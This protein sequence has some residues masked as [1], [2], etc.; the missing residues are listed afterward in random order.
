MKGP[1]HTFLILIISLL[2]G[3]M[4]LSCVEKAAPGNQKRPAIKEDTTKTV[5][6]L[7]EHLIQLEN[8]LI[9]T[10]RLDSLTD[11]KKADSLWASYSKHQQRTLLAINRIDAVRVGPGSKIVVPDTLVEDFN[12]YAPF[13]SRLDILEPIP[14]TVLISRRVQAFGLYECGRL[15][16][17]GPVS[18][19]KQSTPTPAGLNYGNYKAKRKI[20]TVN[21]SWLMPYY[22]NFM[23]FEGVGVHQYLL[24]G[25]PASHACVRLEMADAMFIYEWA[26][27]WELDATRTRVVRNGTPFMVFGDYDFEADVPWLQLVNDPAANEL[28]KQELDILK[29]YTEEYFKDI[30]NFNTIE[31]QQPQGSIAT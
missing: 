19:G 23:N 28:N 31:V 3:S 11:V 30:R 5:S 6:A 20:S 25:F 16:K 14:Q 21:Q 8:E 29:K 27:Q 22:F 12:L 18:T 1:I 24:P 26:Q 9:I 15:I 2:A 17:W 7:K 13:P 10:Y 4:L